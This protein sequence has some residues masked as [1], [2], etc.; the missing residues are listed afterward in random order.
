MRWYAF[1][2]LPI[3]ILGA[4]ASHSQSSFQASSLYQACDN[5]DRTSLAYGVC[6]AY[7]RGALDTYNVIERHF[8]PQKVLCIPKSISVEQIRL[9]FLK[10]AKEKPETTHHDAAFFL[11]MAMAEAWPCSRIQ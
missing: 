9:V 2:L 8:Q 5:S 10:S 4:S 7:I 1:I 3:A 6:S 11:V